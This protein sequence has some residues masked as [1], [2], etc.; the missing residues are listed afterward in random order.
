MSL[1]LAVLEEFGLTIEV[2]RCLLLRSHRM[3]LH[4]LVRQVVATRLLLTF[5]PEAIVAGG[6]RPRIL[7]RRHLIEV[8]R[9]PLVI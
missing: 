8:I 3:S 6:V 2:E 7:L 9:E 4:G 5:L 1:L